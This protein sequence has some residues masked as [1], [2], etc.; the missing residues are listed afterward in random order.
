ME[1]CSIG[2]H[3]CLSSHF[4]LFEGTMSAIFSN[5]LKIQKSPLHQQKLKNSGPVSFKV[6][7]LV[8]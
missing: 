8:H 5:I 4:K 1:F 7:I 2:Y 3:V 6:V